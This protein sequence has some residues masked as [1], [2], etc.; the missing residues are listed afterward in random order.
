MNLTLDP[1]VFPDF[2][3]VY[4]NPFKSELFMKYANMDNGIAILKV[5]DFTGK[6]IINRNIEIS[7]SSGEFYLDLHSLPNGVYFV[8]Y[9]SGDFIY[10]QKVLKE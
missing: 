5:F 8:E 1:P 9:S 7:E 2:A 3:N 4:P 6:T 10:H